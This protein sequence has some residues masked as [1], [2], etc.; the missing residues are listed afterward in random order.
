VAKE[1]EVVCVDCGGSEKVTVMVVCPLCKG[2]KY[3]I[4][5][6]D[7][8]EVLDPCKR[9]N[10]EGAV[11]QKRT[12]PSCRT[13]EFHFDHANDGDSEAKENGLC[14]VCGNTNVEMISGTCTVCDGTGKDKNGKRCPNCKGK[15]KTSELIPCR[16]CIKSGRLSHDSLDI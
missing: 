2:E 9:C 3:K 7:G 11:L 14:P 1:K 6:K 8:E 4:I 5:E 16:I 10:A 15:G 12:C 13:H